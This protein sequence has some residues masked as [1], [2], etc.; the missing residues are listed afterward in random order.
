MSK[1][2]DTYMDSSVVHVFM[3]E[4]AVVCVYYHVNLCVLYMCMYVCV[5]ANVC[6]CVCE[7]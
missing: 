6:I 7:K 5:C 3:C 2:H 4:F 1:F